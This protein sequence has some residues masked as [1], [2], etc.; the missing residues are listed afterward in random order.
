MKKFISAILIASVTLSLVSCSSGVSQE[1]YNALLAENNAL[2]A[3]SSET[4]DAVVITPDTVIDMNNIDGFL[5]TNARFVDTRD[6]QD[7]FSEGYIYGF[8]VV[9]YFDYLEGRALVQNDEWNY[10]SADLVSEEALVKVFGTDKDFPIVLMCT[11]GVRSGYVAEALKDIGYT[12]VHNAGGFNDYKG[13]YQVKGDGVYKTPS[14]ELPSLDGVE[15]TMDNLDQ[16]LFRPNARYV[17]TRNFE[18]M[19]AIG[20]IKGFEVVPF[21]QYLEG[22][23]LT[24]TNT[25]EWVYNPA[26]MVDAEV[27]K[28][29]FGDDLNREIFLMCQGGPRAEYVKGALE[30]I[31]YTNVHNVGGYKNYNGAYK[32]EGVGDYA[33]PTN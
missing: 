32:I 11:V 28:N 30:D 20:Y 25:E 18:D 17:D 24:R 7:M 6:A 23:A 26:D 1:D 9:P 21:F 2:K 33:I 29:V 8:E 3:S 10:T 31:G 12:N 5:G 4:T 14:D 13:I 16:Y 22:R 19:F 27:L 15:V